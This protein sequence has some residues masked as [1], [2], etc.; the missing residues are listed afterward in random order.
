MKLAAQCMCHAIIGYELYTQ[1]ISICILVGQFFFFSLGT[2]GKP[3]EPV[4]TSR[5]SGRGMHFG[6]DLIWLVSNNYVSNNHVSNKYV[7]N[8]CASKN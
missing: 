6:S 7:S 1:D 5:I 8:K 4:M 2:P 3:L